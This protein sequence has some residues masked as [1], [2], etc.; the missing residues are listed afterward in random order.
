MTM[1]NYQ[2]LKARID[3]DITS[4]S[5]NICYWMDVINFEEW[6]EKGITEEY[7]R[8]QIAYLNGQIDILMKV[9]NKYCM[10]IENENTIP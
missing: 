9:M 8:T 2:K 1:N 5:D 6:N 3:E 4:L 7:A 10:E